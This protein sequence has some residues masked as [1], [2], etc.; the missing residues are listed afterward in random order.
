M[1]SDKT[2]CKIVFAVFLFGGINFAVTAQEITGSITGRITD[3]SGAAVV[4]ANV[5]V[6]KITST[7]DPRIL[8]LGLKLNF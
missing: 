2:L 5:T 4:N 7:R 3:K 1:P 8:Q 6:I